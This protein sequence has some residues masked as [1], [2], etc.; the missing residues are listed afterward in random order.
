MLAFYLKRIKW[1]ISV[2]K[3]IFIVIIALSFVLSLFFYFMKG[4]R[5]TQQ[6]TKIDLKQKSRNEIYGIV[7]DPK[8]SQTKQGKLTVKLYR[9]TL[10]GLIGEGCTNNPSD[11][12]KN[13]NNSLFGY[14]TNLI[15]LPYTAPVASG[16]YWVRSGLENAG[17]VPS[18]Y[19][20]EGI[21]FASIKGY[22]KIWSVFRNVTYLFLVLIIVIIGFMIMFRMKLNPQTVIS[23]ESALPKIVIALLLITFSFPI[24]GFLI[25][26]MYVIMSI[27]IAILSQSNVGNLNPG[28]MITLQNKYAGAIFQDI[29]PYDGFPSAFST[30]AALFNVL[31]SYVKVI[32]NSVFSYFVGIGLAKFIAWA[33][34]I[35]KLASATKGIGIEAA[36]FGLNTGNLIGDLLLVLIEIFIFYGIASFVPGIIIGLLIVLT[37]AFFMFKIFFMLLS[38]YIKIVLLIIFSPIIIIFEAIPG[39]TSFTWWI[40]N[41][42]AELL[43]FPIVAIIALTGYAIVQTNNASGQVFSLPFLTGFSSED[44]GVLVGLGIV[45]VTPDI[46]KMIKG[47]LGIKELPISFGIGTFFSGVSAPV[48]GGMGLL[49]QYGS[50]S[51]AV[52]GIRKLANFL[53]PKIGELFKQSQE[54]AGTPPPSHG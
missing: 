33:F 35:E 17:L 36:T 23:I 12:D 14:A 27:G 8:L 10:C 39:N 48:G 29:W 24:A 32:T 16:L 25:D 1:Y 22:A 38:S 4:D 37:L 20:A 49:G 54:T 3:K 28:N 44:L 45:L 11:A 7:N 6:Q 43:S 41:L 47:L 26:G 51:L 9:L 30:G 46:V 53:P 52:P 2:A 19:A 50:L 34:H 40:K 31:P 21:G 5:S 18:A 13:F 15:T 42:F